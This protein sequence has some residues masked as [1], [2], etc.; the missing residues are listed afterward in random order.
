[1][2]CYLGKKQLI[3][4]T[5]QTGRVIVYANSFRPVSW[6]SMWTIALS[7]KFQIKLTLSLILHFSDIH[8]VCIVSA[9][10]F[11][12]MVLSAPERAQICIGSGNMFALVVLLWQHWFGRAPGAV[13]RWWGWF[14]GKRWGCFWV[15]VWN[16]EVEKMIL[17]NCVSCKSVIIFTI[18][19]CYLFWVC[20]CEVARQLCQV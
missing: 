4:I 1:M 5:F 10:P 12:A 20:V 13:A 15:W 19:R 16:I 14:S 9:N 11:K 7:A 8:A 18:T 2:K 6:F 3:N 17:T